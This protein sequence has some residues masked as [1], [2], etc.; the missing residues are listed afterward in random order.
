[1]MG[2]KYYSTYQPN[3]TSPVQANKGAENQAL[4]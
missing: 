1:M 4:L 3:A 2:S